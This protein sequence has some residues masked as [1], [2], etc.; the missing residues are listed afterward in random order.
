MVHGKHKSIWP[1]K[2]TCIVAGL[3]VLIAATLL[4]VGW[5]LKDQ[6]GFGRNSAPHPSTQI[7]QPINQTIQS[8]WDADGVLVW[9]A[10]GQLQ[11]S[12]DGGSGGEYEYA[13]FSIPSSAS[14]WTLNSSSSISVTRRDYSAPTADRFFASVQK[15]LNSRVP[16]NVHVGSILSGYSY[17]FVD[18]SGVRCQWDF[19]DTGGVI[20][21]YVQR[22]R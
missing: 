22:Y 11:V 15:T 14:T 21:V 5:F 7:S 18:S 4:G 8:Y 2:V 9:P 19:L 17:E 1:A 13:I 6:Y 3:L 10:A 12:G 16:S 20:F